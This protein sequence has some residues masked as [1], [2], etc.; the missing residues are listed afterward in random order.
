MISKP[1]HCTTMGTVARSASDRIWLRWGLNATPRVG[2][3]ICVP[4]WYGPSLNGGR[5][6]GGSSPSSTYAGFV[7]FDAKI[8]VTSFP[9]DDW[10]GSAMLL[11]I[12]KKKFPI[13]S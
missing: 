10:K 1:Q 8:G 7:P 13:E 11:E 12:A 3:P 9:A 2:W 6:G 5:Y 4:G